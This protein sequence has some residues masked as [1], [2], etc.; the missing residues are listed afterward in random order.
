MVYHQMRNYLQ[1]TLYYFLLFI[2]MQILPAKDLNNDLI[3]ID[4]RAY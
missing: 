1:M 3:K 4:R 2:I